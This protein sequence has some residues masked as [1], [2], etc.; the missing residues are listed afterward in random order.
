[1][2]KPMKHDLSFA[3]DGILLD[4]MKFFWGDHIDGAISVLADY[5]LHG[6][7]NV[8]FC[9]LLKMKRLA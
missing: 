5:S 9:L 7:R 6:P 4:Q 8:F 1:M 3:P 2:A